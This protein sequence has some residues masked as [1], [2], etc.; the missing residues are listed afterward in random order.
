MNNFNVTIDGA[1]HNVEIHQTEVEPWYCTLTAVQSEGRFGVLKDKEDLTVSNFQEKQ[2]NEER[3]INGGFFGGPQIFD[4]IFDGD[5]VIWK[6]TPLRSLVQDDQLNAYNHYGF[7]LPMDMLKDKK[8]LNK[9]WAKGHAP[10]K[11]WED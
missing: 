10:W 5:D 8:D 7:W 4:C 11:V 1:A 6:Q 3:W 2:K 9:I